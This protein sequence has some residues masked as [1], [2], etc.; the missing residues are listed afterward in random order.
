MYTSVVAYYGHLRHSLQYLK[1]TTDNGFI[2]TQSTTFHCS[3]TTFFI[4]FL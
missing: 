4:D 3:V 1:S 2:S